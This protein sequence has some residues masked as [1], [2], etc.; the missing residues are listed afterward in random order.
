MS[1]ELRAVVRTKDR[2][3]GHGQYVDKADPSCLDDPELALLGVPWETYHQVAIEIGLDV[4]RVPMPDGFTPVSLNLFDEQVSMIVRDYSLKGINVL[5]HCRGES[6]LY[7][8]EGMQLLT[9]LV[10]FVLAVIHFRCASTSHHVISYHSLSHYTSSS[11]SL[12]CSVYLSLTGGVGR[13]GLTASAWAIKMGLVP[14]HPSLVVVEEAA[15]R[16]AQAQAHAY[17]RPSGKTQPS[18]IKVEIPAELEHQIVMSIVERVIAMIR[19]RRGL[20]AI[21]SFEQVQFLASYVRW[22]RATSR[23]KSGM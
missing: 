2:L 13:A 5:V 16:Q 20:K 10:A 3:A 18:T 11:T 4:I 21:E 7:T 12:I 23:E 19:S 22:I 9:T 6:F 14:P 8:F 15:L 17:A 1:G